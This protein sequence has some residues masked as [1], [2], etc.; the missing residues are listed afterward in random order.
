MAGGLLVGLVGIVAVAATGGNK[1]PDR[2]PVLVVGTG[3]GAERQADSAALAIAPVSVEYRVRGTLPD[4]DDEARAYRMGT[5]ATAARVTDLARVLGLSGEAERDDDAWIVRDGDRQLRVESLPGLPWH[6]SST[7][8][9]Q[10]VCAEAVA[11]D[12]PADRANQSS[13]GCA[14][15][16]RGPSGGGEPGSVGGSAGSS[17]PAP[18]S[19]VDDC[20]MP[21]CPE[22]QACI[23]MCPEPQPEPTPEPKPLP[24]EPGPAPERPANLPSQQEAEEHARKLF[25]A[26]GLDAVGARVQVDDGFDRWLVNIEPTVGGLPTIGM[27]WSVGIGPN[28]EVLHAN[29]WLAEPEPGDV[30]PL[31]GVEAALERLRQGALGPGPRILGAPAIEP[32]IDCPPEA[33]CLAPMEPQIRTIVNVRLGLWFSPGFGED[34]QSDAY[35]VPAYLFDIEDG[36]VEPVMAVED[37]YLTQPQPADDSKT[38]EETVPP[39]SFDDPQPAPAPETAPANPQ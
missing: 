39:R 10:V 3:A 24:P 37:R 9:D 26:A 30:Y 20:P 21:P 4:L 17:E 8:P 11:P 13:P 22:G 33:D 23:Q 34:G 28:R 5:D 31:I 12:A 15:V 27:S 7:S 29:G 16:S 25:T 32:A 2:L 38:E 14:P 19:A 6:Y 36:G 35:L 18:P 1:D